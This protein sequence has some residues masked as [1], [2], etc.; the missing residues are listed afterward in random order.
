MILF[1]MV[2]NGFSIVS[3]S[4]PDWL[5]VGGGRKEGA[6]VQRVQR[7]HRVSRWLCQCMAWHG[8]PAPAPVAAALLACPH[9]C[10]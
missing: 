9:L 3:G 8:D 2:T 1:L 4:I 10:S 7:V 5:K 6:A